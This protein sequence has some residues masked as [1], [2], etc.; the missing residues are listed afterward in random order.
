LQLIR[1]L[2]SCFNINFFITQVPYYFS[3]LTFFLNKFNI[4]SNKYYYLPI[5]MIMVFPLRLYSPYF[6]INI[7][8]NCNHL[9]Q[10]IYLSSTNFYFFLSNHFFFYC[11]LCF[12]FLMFV[13][14]LTFLV[15]YLLLGFLNLEVKVPHTWPITG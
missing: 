11:Y 6:A 8:S 15:F 4:F 1:I 10:N 14:L 12:W 9:S 13:F 7:T 2:I 5:P 3:W